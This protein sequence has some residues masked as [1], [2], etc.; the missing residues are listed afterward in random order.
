MNEQ[1]KLQHRHID[2]AE[3]PRCGSTNISCS[4]GDPDGEPEGSVFCQQCAHIYEVVR[5]YGVKYVYWTDDE[6][7]H[8]IYDTDYLARLAATDLLGV[9][10]AA[11]HYIETPGD[12]TDHERVC[13][14][15]DLDFVIAKAKG[16]S[17]A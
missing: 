4:G 11:R 3:C 16:E 8:T 6:G 7:E 2:A 12:F 13:L 5:E 10:E 9:A 14:I 15:Q 17:R 1:V